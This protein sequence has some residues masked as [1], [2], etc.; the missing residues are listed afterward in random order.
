MAIDHFVRAQHH[1]FH[2]VSLNDDVR[3]CAEDFLLLLQGLHVLLRCSAG[4]EERQ[5][6]GIGNHRAFSHQRAFQRFAHAWA[7][8]HFVHQSLD[9]GH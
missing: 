3:Q 7:G 1:R 8:K 6:L 9:C 2:G 5:L 4:G